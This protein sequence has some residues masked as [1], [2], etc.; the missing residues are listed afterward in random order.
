M[1]KRNKLNAAILSVIAGSTAASASAEVEEI[2]VTATKRSESLQDVS[3]AVQAVTEE[4]MDQLGVASFEDYLFQLPGVTAGGSGPGQNTIYIRGVAST[5]PNLT[6]AGVAGLVPNVALYLDEQP[7]SQPGRNLDVYTADMARVEVLAGPQG[8]LFGA[9]SQAGTVRLI[10][11]KPD[12]NEFDASIKVGAATVTEG[13][14]DTNIEVVINAPLSDTFAIRGVFYNDRQGGY[15]DNVAGTLDASES[16]RFR[17]QGTMRANGVPVG[18]LRNGFQAGV[19]LSGVNFIDANNANLVESDFNETTYR[20]ARLMGSWDVTDDWNVLVSHT[21]QDLEADGVFFADPDLGDLEIQR[22]SQDSTDDTFDNTNWTVTGRI[23]ELEAVYTGAFTDRETVQLVDYAD[24]LFV[25]QYLPYYVCDASVTYPGS[26]PLATVDGLPA[27]N[28]QAP[29][30]FVNSL[31][32]TEVTSHEFRLVFDQMGAFRGTVGFFSSE[33]E[34]RERND[35]TYPGAELAAGPGPFVPAGQATVGTGFGPNFSATGSSV[36]DAG[37]WPEAVIFRNDVL[38]TDEQTGAFGEITF[39]LSD[40]FAVTAGARVYDIEV[41][42]VGSAAGSY[43]N[44]GAT[45]D[46]NGGNNLDTLFA[47]PNPDTAQ[48]DGTIF[49]LT[50]TWTPTDDGLFYVT[51]SEGFRPGLLNR[52]GGASNGAG[53]T[54]PFALDTDDVTNLEFGWKLNLADNRLRF[55]GSLFFVDVERLQTTIFDTSIANLFFSDNAADAEVRGLEGDFVWLPEGSDGLTISGAF[56]FLDT[57]ITKVITPT[58]DV[59]RGDSLAFAPEFQ[60]TL[61][62]RYEWE[63]GGNLLAHVMPHLTHSAHSYSDIIRINRDRVDGWTMLGLTAGVSAENWSAELYIDN[64]NDER[65]EVSRSFVFDRQRVSYA[66]PRTIGLR[67]S[68]DF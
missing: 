59:R 56:S 8:T 25:G 9:S 62:A 30:L 50:G 21:T 66:R 31:T 42:L 41:E 38:R 52:P 23:G 68:Y 61:R 15:I 43:G 54:V 22:Y 5:T 26:G 57:E 13:D 1:F 14:T 3:I 46:N 39:D 44:K 53:F 58:N 64:L 37:Q 11:N 16:A 60:A 10:T 40:T 18:A 29:N 32:E 4:T 51:W 63:V 2:V 17:S 65:A 6:T 55:N 27:G 35:F 34:L 49:K 19:D 28:C 24:Y 12:H 33:L 7:L 47:S 67:F 48:T 20:G 36:S 45:Q